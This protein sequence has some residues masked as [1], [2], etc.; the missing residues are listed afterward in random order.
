V[1]ENRT[2]ISGFQSNSEN[3]VV[4]NVG[5]KKQLPERF[6]LRFRDFNLAVESSQVFRFLSASFRYLIPGRQDRPTSLGFKENS[7]P[8]PSKNGGILE[9]I[10]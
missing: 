5:E 7:I 4:E 9:E 2:N 3:L 1:R 10:R 8:P 6:V